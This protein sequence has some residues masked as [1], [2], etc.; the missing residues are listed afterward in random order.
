L[1]RSPDEIPEL[2]GH[3]KLAER[4]PQDVTVPGPHADVRDTLLWRARIVTD[5]NGHATA[6]FRL[7]QEFTP[8]RISAEGFSKGTPVAT[9]SARLTLE[10]LYPPTPFASKFHVP[11][12]LLTGD[13]FDLYVTTE[14]RDGSLDPLE[15]SIGV[16]PCLRSLERSTL[17][18][19]PRKDSLVT[20]FRFEALAPQ[21]NA[22]FTVVCQRGAWRE[23][24][25]SRLSVLR[26]ELTVS[27]GRSGI[28]SGPETLTVEVPADAIPGTVTAYARAADLG[29]AGNAAAATP[30]GS[31]ATN[32]DWLLRE[33]TGCFEQTTSANYP[34]LVILSR[35]RRTSVDPA[36]LEQAA[37]FCRRGFERIL[38]FQGDDGGFSLWQT[39]NQP[40]VRYTAMAIV[41]LAHYGKLFQGKGTHELVRAIEWLAKHPVTGRE[42]VFAALA[43]LDADVPWTD[44]RVL[45]YEPGSAY[46]RALLANVAAEWKGR[47]P[48]ETPRGRLL[49]TLVERLE[50]DMAADGRIASAGP[51]F[52]FS[53][54][55]QLDAET[56]ALSAVAL[57]QSGRPESARRCTGFLASLKTSRGNLLGTHANALAVRALD[58][59]A[60][61]DLPE[62]APAPIPVEFRAGATLPTTSF[63]GGPRNRPVRFERALDATPGSKVSLALEAKT[64]A[65]VEY[66]LGIEY[67]V[68]TPT[69]SSEAPFILRTTLSGVLVA[70][71]MDFLGV[72]IEDLGRKVEGQVLVQISLPGGCVPEHLAEVPKQSGCSSV[73]LRDGALLLY[74][75]HA[76][77]TKS[78]AISVTPKTPGTF[79][80]A[81]SVIYPYYESHREA[82]AAGLEVKILA[83]FETAPRSTPA[84]QVKP[85]TPPHGR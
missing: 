21:S 22:R 27:C 41:Q 34:N 72:E 48:L 78:F 35:L 75:E 45:S 38:T 80:S 52:T 8:L 20:K 68:A 32:E 23:V 33:P 70:T 58:R 50:S 18:L 84:T 9:S 37:Q 11:E 4:P 15:L 64:D 29:V 63:V 31:T 6:T 66:G 16:P 83:P 73:E 62:K 30:A 44:D 39:Q 53:H 67:R 28:A 25:T 17:T 61:G 82:F 13:T 77:G 59:L 49:R 85:P 71:K 79:T 36:V 42:S 10:D 3:G 19:D 57:L 60:T 26:R 46:D 74:Y 5:A 47:W 69:S 1:R 65:K 12:H 14:I 24:T 76:P 43:C 54:G 2:Y 56:T 51:G 81:P 40:T 55:D 7:S